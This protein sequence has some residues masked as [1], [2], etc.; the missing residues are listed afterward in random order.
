MKRQPLISLAA[1]LCAALLLL[2]GCAAAASNP[3]PTPAVSIPPAPAITAACSPSPVP[4]AAASPSPVSEEAAVSALVQSFGKSLQ[5]VSLLDEAGVQQA[6]EAAYGQFVTPELLQAFQAKPAQAPGRMV[7]SPWPDHID[8]FNV[9]K[10]SDTA[11]TVTGQIAEITSDSPE[12]AAR[13]AVTLTVE[14]QAGGAFLISAVT[15]GNYAQKG[16]VVY[17]NTKY[18]FN[19]YLPADWEGY[20]VVNETW[21]GTPTDGGAKQTGPEIILSSPQWTQDTP[22]QDIPLLVFTH[23]QWAQAASENLSVSAAPIPPT[24]LGV[25]AKYVFALPARYNY[26]FPAGYEEVENIIASEPLWPIG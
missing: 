1:L 6:M 25:N 13:R 9:Q 20:T 2:S 7:S 8:I 17:K 23:E 24:V 26:A 15:L 3:A 19:F 22:Y 18:G 16:P 5:S 12:A 21:E 10:D 4:Q 14:E 11:Y